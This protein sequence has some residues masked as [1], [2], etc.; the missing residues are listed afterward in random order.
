MTIMG[1]RIDTELKNVIDSENRDDWVP[2]SMSGNRAPPKAKDQEETKGMTRRSERAQEISDCEVTV[3]EDDFN[4][5]HR[6]F[7]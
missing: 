7:R 4:V 5:Q 2:G 1:F 6:S 3:R